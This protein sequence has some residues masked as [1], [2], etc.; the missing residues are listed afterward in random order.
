MKKQRNVNTAV[1]SHNGNQSS[2]SCIDY[3]DKRSGSVDFTGEAKQSSEQG[4]MIVG[5]LMCGAVPALVVGFGAFLYH[6]GYQHGA[7]ESR[8]T[9]VHGN[10]HNT[11]I[12]NVAPS[13]AIAPACAYGSNNSNNSNNQHKPKPY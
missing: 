12:Y 13:M 9:I 10:Q 1:D 4:S 11:R 8:P 6:T 3:S 5:S 7:Q 2:D